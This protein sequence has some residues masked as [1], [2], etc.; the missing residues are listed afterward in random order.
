MHFCNFLKWRC[1]KGTTRT[2][3]KRHLQIS[4]GSVGIWFVASMMRTRVFGITL[5]G[6]A[7]VLHHG[8]TTQFFFLK[9]QKT[10]KVDPISMVFNVVST[11]CNYQKTW[12]VGPRSMVFNVVSTFFNYQKTWKVCPRSRLFYM[13]S[14]FLN[15]PQNLKSRSQI[16]VFLFGFY[17]FKLHPKPMK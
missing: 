16:N 11:F 3:M 9:Y 7:R 5:L 12:K 14:T 4:N 8:K 15:Y 6:N 17:F 10:W 2:T 1:I 13:A